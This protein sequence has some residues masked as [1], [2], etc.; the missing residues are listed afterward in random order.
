[1]YIDRLALKQFS[2]IRMST[3]KPRA[4]W[5]GLEYLAIT[6]IITLLCYRLSGYEEAVNALY[7][8][9]LE[10]EAV[11]LEM[12]G[13]YWPATS[14]INWVLTFLLFVL[15]QVVTVGFTGYSMMVVKGEN[16]G[17]RDL[18]RSFEHL[19]RLIVI[20]V[21]ESI[22]VAVG[23]MLLVFPGII[24]SY[25]FRQAY[26]VMYDNPEM[27]AVQCLRES[28]RLMRG[29]KLELFVYDISFIGWHLASGFVSAF[30][31]IAVLDVFI[32]PYMSF[33]FAA[34]YYILSGQGVPGLTRPFESDA[35]P[36]SPGGG[37]EN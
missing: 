26:H 30:V 13:Q 33:T 35:A 29:H 36:G 4:V 28:W 12:L 15:V 10:E 1:M 7:K 23:S 21:L 25:G 8:L 18:F 19:V 31:G 34:Y 5:I 20:W 11:T 14:T 27:G 16:A 9:V 32:Q 6:G 3:V 37:P 17:Y 2:K 22:V 24:A